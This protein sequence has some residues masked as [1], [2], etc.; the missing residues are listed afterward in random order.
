MKAMQSMMSLA[1]SLLATSLLVGALPDTRQWSSL[2]ER[3]EF[4]LD[5]H[6]LV[7][8][9]VKEE[10]LNEDPFQHTMVIIV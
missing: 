2:A 9:E 10:F 5:M 1:F 7:N 6:D 3:K 4:A 8:R